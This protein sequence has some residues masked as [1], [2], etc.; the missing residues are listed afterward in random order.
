MVNVE[1]WAHGHSVTL[2]I[3]FTSISV[4]LFSWCSNM[5]GGVMECASCSVCVCVLHFL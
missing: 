4:I 1:V 5:T 3:K 2:E